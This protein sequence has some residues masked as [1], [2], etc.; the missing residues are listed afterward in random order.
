MSRRID[1]GSPTLNDAF[2]ELRADYDLSKQ[3]RFRRSRSGVSAVGKHADYH[4]RSESQFFRAMELS[5]D[6]DRN[7]IV[8]GQAVDRL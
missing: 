6:I 7:D 3:T 8:V 4:Y 1:I 2:D 5:R